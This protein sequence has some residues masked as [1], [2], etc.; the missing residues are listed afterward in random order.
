MM[1]EKKIIAIIGAG[2]SGV[3]F[4]LRYIKYHDKN[5]Y[6]III[7][8]NADKPLKKLALTGN[9]KCNFANEN[10]DIKSKYFPYNRQI[11]NILN[12]YKYSQISADFRQLGII[13]KVSNGLYYPYSESSKTVVNLFLKSLE[14]SDIEI[15]NNVEIIDYFKKEGG[16]QL[17]D[18][19]QNTYFVNTI[20][21]ASGGK[22]YP[23]TG[24]NGNLLNTLKKHHYQ[25]NDFKPSLCPIYIKENTKL[26]EGIRSKGL[27]SLFCNNELV[28]QEDGEILF[29]DGALSGIVTMN[30][31]HF[32]NQLNDEKNIVISVD[33][34]PDYRIKIP[35][36]DYIN[37]IK[38]E[39]ANYLIKHSLDIHD[40]KF[41]YR[42]MFDFN[43]AQVSY[44][45]VSINQLNEN[46]ESKIEKDVYFIGEIIDVAGVCGGYNLMWAFASA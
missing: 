28:H 27:V 42:K 33:L 15:K 16:Y 10:E 17:V 22:S 31:S 18:N 12:D 1:E 46:L 34:V 9:G 13:Y 21:F 7:F 8:N 19:Q 25:I 36:K 5:A 20:V 29:K 24:S 6:K 11:E 3:Y 35:Q 23:A 39:L 37:F 38:N 45:G 14:K 30:M 41:T 32:I 2:A 44:G 43:V 26:I 4:A 40:V